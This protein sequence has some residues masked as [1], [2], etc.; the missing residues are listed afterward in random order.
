MNGHI[1][2][3]GGG[4]LLTEMTNPLLGNFILSLSRRQPARV[5]FIPTASADAANSIVMFYRAFSGRCIPADLTLFDVS[6]LPRRPAQSSDLAAFVA[7]QDVFYVG[8]GNTANLLALW[9]VH[10]LDA[11]LR[12][13]WLNGAVLSGVSAGMLCWFSGGITDSYGDLRPLNDGLGLISASAC[14]HYDGEP[15]RRP[16]YHRAIAEGLQSGYAA[17]D[18]AA[19]H[20]RGTELIESVSALPQAAAYKLELAEGR[21]LETRL[22]TR[23]LG[24]GS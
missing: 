10:G 11:L 8:G 20:F 5:C 9:R 24:A 7:D 18:G 13:A 2:A 4:G 15:Q 21:V 1:V 23:F 6:N 16:T 3:I 17:D 19:L 12:N 22:P 14:P